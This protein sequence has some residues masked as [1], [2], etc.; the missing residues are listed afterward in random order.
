MTRLSLPAAGVAALL[1][2]NAAAATSPPDPPPLAAAYVGSASGR[3]ME[4]PIP[5]ETRY[6]GFN[7]PVL[8]A[9][10]E[11]ALARNIDL[12]VGLAR[13][14]AARALRLG[15][16]AEGR[17]ELDLGADGGR[18]RV[19]AYQ[20]G[21]TQPTQQNAYDANLSASREIDLF[22]RIRKGVDAAQADAVASEEDLRS[23]RISVANAVVRTYLTIR[24]LDRRLVI[25]RDEQR[26]QADMASFTR[27]M[28]DAGSVPRADLDRA[29]AQAAT[30]AAEIPSM[31]LERELQAQRLAV[32]LATTP[33]EVFGML[34]Q[35]GDPASQPDVPAGVPADLLRRRPD[36]RAAEARVIAAYGRLGV[37]EADLKPRFELVG[38]VGTLMDAFSGVGFARSIE[39]LARASVNVP[40][41]DGGRRQSAVALRRAE[42]DEARLHYQSTVLAAV[43]DVEGA[44]ASLTRDRARAQALQLAAAKAASASGQVRTAWRAGQLPILDALEADRIRLES[45]DALTQSQTAVLRDQA[46]LYASLGGCIRLTASGI[47]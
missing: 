27:R 45:E 10:V 11:R 1:A 18:Q 38:M 39:W 33:Q 23:T 3:G 21:Y 22:G 2:F 34:A 28:F 30:T 8:S 37:A 41:F 20:I 14:D 31:E 5:L 26:T 13:I 12:R 16:K 9:L 36:V 40:L 15:A 7:D 29:E 24:G 32:L 43:Q 35:A 4:A 19:S 17:P 46:Q 42:A 47:C 44:L 25:L 6:Q